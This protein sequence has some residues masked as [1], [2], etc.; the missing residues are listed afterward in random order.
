MLNPHTE[1]ERA[2]LHMQ[3]FQI[4]VAKFIC[5]L[6]I[7]TIHTRPF[8]GISG[9]LDFYLSDAISRV[10]VPLF[11]AISGYFFFRS[12]CYENGK[13][14]NCTSNRKRL[15]KYLKRF[16]LL[17]VGFALFYTIL[18]LPGWY[19]AGWWGMTAVKDSF[20]AFFFRGSYYHLWYLLALVYALPLA[21]LLFSYV[22]IRYCAII[23]SV[24]WCIECLLYSYNWISLTA[25]SSL[26]WLTN[27]FPIVFDAVFRAIPLLGV[28]IVAMR[29]PFRHKNQ[30]VFCATFSIIAYI[31]E[32]S[33]LHFC[34]PNGERYS[35]LIFTPVMAYFVLQMLLLIPVKERPILGKI[36]RNSSLLIYCIHPF[37]IEIFTAAGV[38]SPP[39]MWFLVTA[40]SILASVLWAISRINKQ[41]AA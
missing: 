27:H 17:Y 4:D 20:L 12:L 39:L 19:R 10:A 34:T 2:D 14:V 22:S 15:L 41:R 8:S 25:S 33:I 9:L 5:A 38:T 40:C 18:Q 23:I 28:G 31:A 1:T 11:F 32:A 3:F 24:L 16:G 36:L 29:Y 13:I 21:Y 35:Y 6:L 30:T 26:N 37:F 7:I